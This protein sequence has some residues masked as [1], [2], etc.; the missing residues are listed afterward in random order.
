M[1]VSY[2][3]KLSSESTSLKRLSFGLSYDG[4]Q[5]YINQSDLTNI[6]D[7]ALKHGKYSYFN[8]NSNVGVFLMWD[9]FYAGIAGS[10]ILSG[11]YNEDNYENS[12]FPRNYNA[13]VGWKLKQNNEFYIEPSVM[14]RVI[15]N[16]DNHL[17]L[18]AKFYYVPTTTR[19]KNAGYWT[20]V[21]YRTSWKEFPISSV[22]VSAFLGGSHEDFYYGYSYEV[23][24]DKYQAHHT[25]SHQFMIGYTLSLKADRKCGCTPFSIPVL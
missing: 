7:P 8:H 25:G 9:G 24:I 18:N 21:S 6:N 4:A 1:A 22:S 16:Y 14:L 20:G 10:H 23:M 13:L 19:R 5:K 17:D 11:G 15:E 2:T 3:L 12:F